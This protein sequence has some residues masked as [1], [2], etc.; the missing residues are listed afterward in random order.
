MNHWQSI[1]QKIVTL[2]ELL[3]HLQQKREKR[4]VFTNGCF[5]LLHQGHIHYLSHARDLGDILI[6]GLNSDTSIR[7][8]KGPQRPIVSEKER[9]LMLAAFEFIDYVVL[10]EE[11]T[12]INLI[13]SISPDILVKGGDYKIEE[14]VGYD[15]VTSNGGMVLTL[16]L[17]Q[18]CST[19]NII[20]KI[21]QQIQ[22]NN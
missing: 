6:V 11:D 8:L 22:N 16:D 10:F 13:S 1:Q 20:E 3:L 9:A 2:P 15:V 17:I 5:D 14:I 18:G 12:P 7:R 21:A 19:T 4:V